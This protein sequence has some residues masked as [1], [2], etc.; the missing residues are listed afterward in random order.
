MLNV[1]SSSQVLAVLQQKK[2]PAQATYLAMYSTWLGG[3]TT[4]PSLM[5][6]PI[7]DHIVHRGDGVFEAIK[8]VN[9]KIYLLQPHL[10]RLEISA[11]KIGLQLPHSKEE[12]KKI[13][14][15]MSLIVKKPNLMYR[16]YIS[17]GP[18]GFTAN[19]YESLAAQMYLVLTEYKPLP[20]EKFATGVKVGRS[21]VPVK[22]P[23]LAR[24]KTCNYL[25]NVLMKKE[26]V[27]AG[28]DFTVAFDKEG[29]LAESST[30]NM[31][32]VDSKRRLLRPRLLQILKGTTMMRTLDLAQ[33]LL[34]DGI[35]TSI[36]ESDIT[37]SDI[38][39][40]H[41]VM[42]IGTTLDILPVVEYEGQKVGSAG[43][44]GLAGPVAQQLL[45]MLRKD[46]QAG[47][48]VDSVEL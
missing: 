10:D 25:P 2:Y 47:P 34:H 6:V 1:L 41:E 3:V 15:Q 18:G 20:A 8:C 21:S 29:Y 26:S 31:V 4:D 24:T 27:D 45:A 13:I 37:E 39:T 17:R 11:E 44:A 32:I 19:P 7:D 30:E 35:I 22:E 14:F 40:A 33:T 42:M 46:Q 36:D 12:I 9:G 16:L 38:K 48:F 43:A 28:V 23:W 5:I